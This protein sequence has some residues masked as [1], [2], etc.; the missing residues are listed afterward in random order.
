M[1]AIAVQMWT[2][3]KKAEAD[4]AATLRELKSIGFEAVEA[5][6][7]M[8]GLSAKEM[9]LQLDDAGLSLCSV[10]GRLPDGDG[11]DE[12]ERLCSEVAELGA[13]ALVVSSLRDEYF[14]DDEGVGRGAARMNAAVGAAERHGLELG[15]HNHWWEF[16]SEIG[17]RS[18]YEVFVERLD[19]S[20]ALEVD[21]YWAQVGG[22]DAAGLVASLGG[23]VH[24][25][26]IKD[27]PVDRSS[28][29]SAVGKG[30]MDV[31][32][33]LSANS[34]VRWFIIELDDFD[35]EIYD[36]VRDSFAYLAPR[37]R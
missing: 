10:H 6:N 13:P 1:S 32:A 11:P 33:V 29:Q 4:F 16:G 36:A 26:H 21:T 35:G 24:Y 19:P 31:P 20:I 14:G 22:V 18:A 25:L 30:R 9:R 37:V 15:Y 3:R 2:V 28:P 27:G 12:I 17:G 34:A 8:A 7:G 23:R 5:V